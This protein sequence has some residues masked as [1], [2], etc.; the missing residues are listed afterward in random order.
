MV[1]QAQASRECQI[2]EPKDLSRSLRGK[3]IKRVRFNDEELQESIDVEIADSTEARDG[4]TD[5]AAVQSQKR[6]RD[7][8]DVGEKEWTSMS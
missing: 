2:L 7:I 4:S 6:K 8:D 5:G 3:Q 1:P